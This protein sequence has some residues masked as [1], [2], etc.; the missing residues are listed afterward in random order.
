MTRKV[1]VLVSEHGMTDNA[2]GNASASASERE[3]ERGRESGKRGMRG[4]EKEWEGEMGGGGDGCGKLCGAI[5]AEMR[6]R[7]ETIKTHLILREGEWESK[8]KTEREATKS[9]GPLDQWQVDNHCFFPL[10]W[11]L[12]PVCYFILST[13]L[14][15]AQV[16]RKTSFNDVMGCSVDVVLHASPCGLWG[17]RLIHTRV[18]RTSQ[19]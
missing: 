18:A 14:G 7:V 19:P 11:L 9:I 4:R 6:E 3:G 8:M 17:T 16:S 5:R 13:L 1:K 12:T 15:T 10:G 2:N